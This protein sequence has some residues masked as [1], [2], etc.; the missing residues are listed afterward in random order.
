[1]ASP[2]QN[3]DVSTPQKVVGRFAPS[4]A[5]VMHAGNIFAALMAWLI[6]KSHDGDIVLRIEDLDK[7]RSKKHF[8]DKV[9]RDF[10]SLGLTWDRGPVFQSERDEAYQE[11]YAALE[12]GADLYPCFCSRADL[13]A[14]SAPHRGEKQVYPRT[15]KNLTAQALQEL[16]ATRA[17]EGRGPS[18]RITV[19]NEVV[20]FHDLFQDTMTQN[21]ETECGDFI[22]RR[23][24]GGFAYQLAVVVDDAAEGITSV[25]RG[26]DLLV[27]TPQQIFL[28]H[29]LGYSTPTYAHVP[30][31]CAPD[32]RRLAKRNKSAAFDELLATLGNPRA[33]IGHI[34]YIGGLIECDEPISPEELLKTFDPEALKPRYKNTPGIQFDL[35]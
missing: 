8:A 29:L 27:S 32:G 6:A 15:C 1:M 4:P 16:K 13:N 3:R 7:E 23:A 28:Q 24:D 26:Y 10:E 5:G 30:L 35:S 21:L 17:Q 11:A 18:Y 19:S 2:F 33:V 9:Q 22:I 25:V 14:Q 34:A 20:S 31:F 12:R